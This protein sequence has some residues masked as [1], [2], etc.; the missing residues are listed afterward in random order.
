MKITTIVLASA[1]AMPSSLAFAQAGEGDAGYAGNASSG[2]YGGPG[3]SG[4][5]AA[6]PRWQS[7]AW[8]PEARYPRLAPAPRGWA[9]YRR[10]YR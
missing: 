6:Y 2:G 10:E 5:Y 3:Y 1:L 4:V 7:Y 9:P 8:E